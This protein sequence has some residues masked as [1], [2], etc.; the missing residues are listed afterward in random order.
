MQ[1]YDVLID[2]GERTGATLLVLFIIDGEGKLRQNTLND[3]SVGRNVDEIL[4]LVHGR[5]RQGVYCGLEE[6]Q[7]DD[8]ADGG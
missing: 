2:V 6:G 7:Q 5:A 1:A 3:C 8:Q 4:R